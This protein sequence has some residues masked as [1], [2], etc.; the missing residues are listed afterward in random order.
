MSEAGNKRKARDKAFYI[1]SAKQ[2]RRSAG[3][4][5]PGI[6][7]FLCTSNR[8]KDSVREAYNLLNEH[9]DIIYGTTEVKED[10][11]GKEEDLEIEDELSKEV[12][13]LKKMQA[14]PVSER[15]FQS[16]ATGVKG[17][18]F[19]R[20]TVENPSELV[21]AIITDIEKKQQQTTKFLLRMLPIQATCKSVLADILKTAESLIDKMTGFKSFSLI[22]KVRNHNLKRDEIIAPLADLVKKQYPEIKVDLDN[23][24]TSVVVEVLRGTCCLGIVTNYSGRSK[25]NLVEIAQ[26]ANK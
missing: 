4:L 13:N 22:V 11:K 21:D 18:L 24:E 5:G 26:K 8:E 15:R 12:E 3:E 17:C 23:P 10:T 7:G 19:I 1:K 25:Y 6:K 14:V 9:A 16:V 2:A 20:S